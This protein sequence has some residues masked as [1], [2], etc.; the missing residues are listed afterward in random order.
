MSEEV[1][2]PIQFKTAAEWRQWAC[3]LGLKSHKELRQADKLSAV[4]TGRA[5]ILGAWREAIEQG[6]AR[7]WTTD[8]ATNA[9]VLH[10]AKTG[11]GISRSS[12]YDWWDNYQ[13]GGIAALVDGRSLDRLIGKIKPNNLAAKAAEIAK[14]LQDAGVSWEM[15][16]DGVIV[17]GV[18]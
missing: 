13:V 4:A 9:F 17:R 10:L 8:Q 18:K 5:K 7:S 14:A 1:K 12:I 2:T 6:K 11:R 3:A 15:T 16:F